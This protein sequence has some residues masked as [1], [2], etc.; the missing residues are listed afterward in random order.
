MRKYNLK[1]KKFFTEISSHQ[2]FYLKMERWDLQILDFHKWNNNRKNNIQKWADFKLVLL[3]ICHPRLFLLIIMITIQMFGLLG[4]C[5][6]RWY[7]VIGFLII[8]RNCSFFL[9]GL[10]WI[11]RETQNVPKRL[12]YCISSK[13]SIKFYFCY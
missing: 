13:N 2:T 12:L 7:L 6:M 5:I 9:D 4:F 1:D 11:D 10:A 3:C 8:N